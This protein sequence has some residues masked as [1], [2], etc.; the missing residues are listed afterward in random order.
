M[1]TLLDSQR[2]AWSIHNAAAKAAK[3]AG[4]CWQCCAEA[5]CRA[6]DAAGISRRE[7]ID[8]R[9]HAECSAR[10]ARGAQSRA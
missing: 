7:H 1:M 2:L 6:T 9:M 8:Y 10:I 4:A 3:T 5:G